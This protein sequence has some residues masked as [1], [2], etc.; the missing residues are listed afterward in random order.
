MATDVTRL[1][2]IVKMERSAV[3]KPAIAQMDAIRAL[4]EHFVIK[5]DGTFTDNNQRSYAGSN[6]YSRL[7][8]I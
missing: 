6:V 4:K 2:I 7:S 3:S 5:V 8:Y 1:V